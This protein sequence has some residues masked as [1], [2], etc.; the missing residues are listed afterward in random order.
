MLELTLGEFQGCHRLYGG[1]TWPAGTAKSI[2]SVKNCCKEYAS[3]DQ[4][5][6]RKE[7]MN[8]QLEA[9]S[10]C[11]GERR[12]PLLLYHK[13]CQIRFRFGKQHFPNNKM[14]PGGLSEGNLH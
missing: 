13:E 12:Y 1:D 2:L 7:M 9:G 3:Q 6:E 8:E 4:L 11:K 5:E 10:N 14:T